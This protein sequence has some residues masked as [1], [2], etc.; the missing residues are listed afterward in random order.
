MADIVCPYCEAI[1]SDCNNGGDA[2]PWWEDQYT[3]DGDCEHQCDRCGREMIIE[4]SW[5]PN[6]EARAADID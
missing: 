4:V 1:Q 5:T 3:P 6:F 2:G